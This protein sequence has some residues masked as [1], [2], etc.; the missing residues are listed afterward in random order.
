MIRSVLILVRCVG[1]F[2]WGFTTVSSAH[3][4][5]L[6]GSQSWPDREWKRLEEEEK[7]K[8]E[9]QPAPDWPTL[10]DEARK[11]RESGRDFLAFGEFQRVYV[12]LAIGNDIISENDEGRSH[13]VE[14]GINFLGE[15]GKWRAG[16]DS[17]VFVD[18]YKDPDSPERELTRF[19]ELTNFRLQYDS[20]PR[21][22]DDSRWAT[23]YRVGVGAQSYGDD[24]AWYGAAKQRELVHDGLDSLDMGSES[25]NPVYGTQR[26]WSATAMADIS[27]FTKSRNGRFYCRGTLGLELNSEWERSY[28]KGEL[29]GGVAVCSF[30]DIRGR[31][32]ILQ[33][34]TGERDTSA[35]IGAVLNIFDCQST[36]A[37]LSLT[38]GKLLEENNDINPYPDGDSVL[39]IGFG[40]VTRF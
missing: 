32:R 6:Q 14:F 39:F 11:R 25:V 19:K 23:S 31:C 17:V 15:H 7:K 22:D 10:L 13:E 28:A 30:L 21:F 12:E 35:S 18:K 34:P 26:D 37:G 36:T 40:G 4:Q 33:S 27:A 8:K 3:A 9:E 20:R 1:V 38:Y 2:F 16:Y 29:E 5:L 24:N